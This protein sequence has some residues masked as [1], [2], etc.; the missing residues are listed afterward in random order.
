MRL[1]SGAPVSD[2]A[3][4]SF[5][6]RI[7]YQQ[8]DAR[9]PEQFDALAA[10]LGENRAPVTVC[11]L[12]T[13]PGIFVDI[14]A[15]LARVG[16]NTPNVRLVLE[17]P[18]GTDLASNERINSAVAEFFA[19]DQ[20]YRIDHYLGKESVQNLMAI[21][22]GNALFEPLWRREWI[23]DVQITIAEQLGVEKRGDFYDG[24]GALRDMVQN[25]LLQLVCIVAME[26]PASLSQ[27]A[28]RDEKLKILKALKPIPLQGGAREDR[29]RPVSGGRHRRA[30]GAGLP[31]RARYSA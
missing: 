19:E 14:C 25:H 24:V 8:V 16:L 2:D 6:A 15:Q 27:D 13:A 22:F 5:V 26:P 7:V 18:L 21:R 4:A 17:K 28:I 1:Y 20:I 3:W 12:A 30:A 29:A 23:K 11:Y 31:G 9:K 10:A